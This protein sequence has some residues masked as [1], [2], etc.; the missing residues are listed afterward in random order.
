M[1]KTIPYLEVENAKLT[2]KN[3]SGV[4]TKFNRAGNRNFHVIIDDEDLAK[5]LMDEGW[6]IRI[7]DKNPEYEPF[8]SLQVSV[9]F[10][11]L[12]PD[13]FLITGSSRKPVRLDEE[14]IGLIDHADILNV[15]LIVRP[16][17]WE[18]NGKDGIK[19][20]L[21]TMYVTIQEDRFANKYMGDSY[22]E[23]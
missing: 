15:D 11:I 10:D 13:V 16:R 23:F 8:Y 20:Y 4:E 1:S 22:D 9:R 7:H 21:K 18:V 5:K 3:F 2:F 19:A 17:Y 14:N 12:P 6:N